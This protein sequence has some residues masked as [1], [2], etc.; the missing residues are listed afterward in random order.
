MA[1]FNRLFSP[2]RP[3]DPIAAEAIK[4]WIR[5]HLKDGRTAPEDVAVTVSEII[6]NDPACPGTETVVLIMRPYHTTKAVKFAKSMDEVV[7]TDIVASL[8]PEL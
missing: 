1:L 6:C 7:E 4:G 5:T 8:V 2:A 3:R